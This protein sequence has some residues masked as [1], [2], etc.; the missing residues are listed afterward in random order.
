MNE[1]RIQAYLSGTLSEGDAE[2][3][4]ERLL[5]DDQLAEELQSALEI[6]AAMMSSGASRNRRTPGRSGRAL[7]PLAIAAGAVMLAAGLFWLRTPPESTP[8]FRG[9]EQRMGL[10]V[11]VVDGELSAWWD[12]VS[13]AAGYELRVFASD[14]RLMHGVEVDTA[15]A[16]VDLRA[17]AGAGETPQPAFV[18]VVALDDFGQA[19]NRSQRIALP[20][21]NGPSR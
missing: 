19:L 20:D 21:S 4:E 7:L 10:V 9:V 3:F 6:R 16:A 1:Q 5:A 2:T 12:P 17:A 14:G 18:D 15:T 13:G 11:E 8:L